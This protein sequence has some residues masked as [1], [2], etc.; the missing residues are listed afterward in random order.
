MMLV[1]GDLVRIPQGAV[2]MGIE[3]DRTPIR[4]AVDPTMAIVIDN[5]PIGDDL[6]KILVNEE[7]V[8]VDK[9][10]VRLVGG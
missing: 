8:F 3:S 5:R 1:N 10:V 6:I 4:V 2:I 9:R 7:V